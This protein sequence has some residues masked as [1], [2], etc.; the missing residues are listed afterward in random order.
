MV[1]WVSPTDYPA[2]QSD[3]IG[4][5]QKGTG[6]WFLDAPEFAKWLGEPKGTLFCPGIPGA[7]KTMVAAIAIDHLLKSAQSSSLGVAYV[8][9]NYKAKEEQDASSMLAAIV[10]Q[11]VQG[12][13][14]TAEPVERLYKQHADRGTKPSL[15]E[16]FGALRE[17]VAMHPTVYIAIDALDECRDSDGTRRLFLARLRDLQAGQDVR[18]VT[19]SR[20]IPQV[21][22]EFKQAH[23]LEVRAS[24][25]DVRRFIAGQMYRLPKCIQRDPALQQMVEEKI[26]EKVDGMF[27]LARLHIDSLSDKTTAKKVRTTLDNLLK[28][29]A[30]LNDAYEDALQRIKSQLDGHYELAK[31]VLLWITYAR[32]PLT[33]AE[34]CCALA[35]EL[36]EPELDPDNLPDVEDLLSVCAGLV[37]VDRESAVIRLVHYTTQEYFERIRDTWDPSAPLHITLT[38]LTY[39]SFDVFKTGSCSFDKE[40]DKRLKES[41]FLDYAANH[42]GEHIVKVESDAC[43]LVYLFLSNSC[44]V[45]SA[46]QVLLAPRYKYRGYSQKYPKNSTGLHL[47]ARFGISSTLEKLLSSQ[48]QEKKLVLERKDSYDQA[49]LYLAA[50]NGHYGTTELLLEKGADVNAQGGEYGNALQAASA[51]GHEAIVK[52]LLDK[53]ADVNA[54]GG[55][56]GNA[57]QAASAG[58]HEAIV[59]LLLNKGADVNAQGGGYGNA[60]Q[61]A[62]A[63]GHEAIVKLLLNKGAD[64]N[65]QGGGYGNALQAASAGGH[66]AIVKLLLNKGADVNAQGGEYGNALQAA[67][68][69]GHEAIVKLLLDKGA[70]VNAQGGYYGNALQAASARGHEAIVKLLL[71]K[72]ADVNAQGGGYGNALQ[73]A[74]AGG[75]EAI[76]KLLLD[77]GADVNAQ[78]GGYGNALQAASARGHEA[79]VKLLLDKGAGVNAQGRE[80][81]NAL[82]A[83]SARGHEAIVKLL[84]DKGADVNAQGGGYGNAL[85]A[86]SARGH[87]AIVKLLLD[88]G[89]DVNAQG[90]GYGNALQAAS[91][92]GHEAIVKLLLD[93]GADV[94]AQGGGYGNALQAASAGGHEAIVKLLLD[95]GADVNA[96]GGGYGNALQAA[97]AGG[98]EAIVKLLLNKGADV[99]AQGGGYG[100]ALQ[101]ASAGGHEAIVKLLLNKGADVNAQGGEYGNALQAASA[102]GHEAIVKLLLDKGAGVNAQGR[103]CGNVTYAD[104]I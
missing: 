74:S 102:G 10:K 97:S 46:T 13:P 70:D 81:G 95:K 60:L 88:K 11:L 77:K 73:A 93:K 4:R 83:A 58:G 42:W 39:L 57:L 80:Y 64:V 63:G 30:A 92:R 71:N 52:L 14:S 79:I 20:F 66:E 89:A 3:I 84:L 50:D 41:K 40:F 25:E 65:A 100:N 32:R 62:S 82:Q 68:A 59:K 91:A 28:G 1:G 26:A 43:A 53:G 75:H 24:N 48:G 96:Q 2:Q 31:K 33:T 12:R 7:G 29:S 76:V 56:Y 5:R 27:L 19:T 94:N 44:L 15:E 37:V 47:A 86:A 16:I 90:G 104:S 72:G 54:Q 103:V 78:G 18:L 69:G 34:L 51:R 35:V 99:N 67:S 55:G 101:A 9:C 36:E 87:E 21:E 49:L 23:R 8:Y 38:C 45:S 17:V 61:A 85:Q 98:H 6:Q 22:T